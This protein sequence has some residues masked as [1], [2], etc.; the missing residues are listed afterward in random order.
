MVDSDVT[1][2]Y[3]IRRLWVIRR[4]ETLTYNIVE[5][6]KALP[7]NKEQVWSSYDNSRWILQGK[8]PSLN[9][10]V[11]LLYMALFD[12]LKSMILHVV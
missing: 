11:F 7:E 5:I 12:C 9:Y 10:K 6:S 3:S 1:L 2:E 4:Y 8:M